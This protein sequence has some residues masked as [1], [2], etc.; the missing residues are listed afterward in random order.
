MRALSR[1]PALVPRRL[2]ARR[3]PASSV[4]VLSSRA[5]PRAL[6][7]RPRRSGRDRHAAAH[8]GRWRHFSWR[9]WMGVA[10]APSRGAD[11][12][13]PRICED[14]PLQGVRVV[15]FGQLLAGPFVGTLLGDFGAEVIKVEPPPA[16]D[17]MRDWGRLR[18]RDHSLWWSILARNKRSVTLN[19]RSRGGPADR[20]GA[21]LRRRRRGRELPSGDDGALGT[22]TRGR[23]R[24]SIHARYTRASPATGRPAG[25]ET[26]PA[27]RPPARR[28]PAS[29]H[30]N[31]YPGQAPPR[32]GISLG[33]TLAA[34]SAFQGIL[35]A[36]YARDVRRRRGPGCRRVDHG[37]VPGDDG[38]RGARVR[39]D[40]NRARADRPSPAADRSEQRL[41][42]KG[43]QVG[44]D[45]RQS[46]HAVAS[47]RGADRASGAGRG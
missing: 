43:R 3:R 5:R 32:Y 37:R 15:E 18:H 13:R 20:A 19:L 36:L 21:R 47:A 39:E 33:D 46:R 23:A 41:S 11:E 17:A 31:G 8:P 22:R 29:R 12:R 27:L 30:I 35:L 45:R 2:L 6:A 26:G 38:V 40:G 24:R 16:G 9:C 10:E 4:A 14:G 25:T 44:G 28:S 7:Q 34:Q 42:V 1:D